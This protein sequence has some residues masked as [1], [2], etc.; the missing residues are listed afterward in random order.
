MP[1]FSPIEGTNDDQNTEDFS[2]IT[3]YERLIA[4]LDEAIAI[5]EGNNDCSLEVSTGEDEV[6]ASQPE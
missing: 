4:I 6:P 1:F 3:E 2:P 5:C